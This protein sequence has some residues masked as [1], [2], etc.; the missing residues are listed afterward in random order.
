MDLFSKIFIFSKNTSNTRLDRTWMSEQ[1]MPF[2][3]LTEQ[4]N[5][6]YACPNIKM[7]FMHVR[8]EKMPFTA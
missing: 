7:P 5:A 6:I 2:K 4:E 3:A 1:K 8:T